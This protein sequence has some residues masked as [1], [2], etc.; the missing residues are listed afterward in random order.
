MSREKRG[1]QDGNDRVASIA[2][3]LN[4]PI[5][6]NEVSALVLSIWRP[7]ENPTIV[8]RWLRKEVTRDLAPEVNAFMLDF[9][10]DEGA[11][12]R[13][14]LQWLLPDGAEWCA[15][16]FRIS[17]ADKP[18][19]REQLDG[20]PISL[21]MQLQRHNEAF[22]QTLVKMVE[23]VESR[24]V[25]VFEMV[26]KQ[27][28]RTNALLETA[29]ADR[30]E[31]TFAAEEASEI[32]QEATETAAKAIEEAEDARKNDKTGQIIEMAVKQLTGG[33]A[34]PEAT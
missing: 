8:A 18:D 26:D 19:H 4:T 28:A 34:A 13:A 10:A 17:C 12:C 31:A 9:A 25:S 5:G 2:R 29:Q 16:T 7:D 32:A 3:W 30:D 27:L 21:I 14:K 24:Y 22:A 20:T 23:G 1:L 6:N 11:N 15:K 33:V